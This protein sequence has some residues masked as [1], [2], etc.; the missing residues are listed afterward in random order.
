MAAKKYE[1]YLLKKF[2]SVPPPFAADT[3]AGLQWGISGART[4]PGATIHFGGE[5]FVK[6]ILL[7]EAPHTHDAD[8]YLIFMGGQL[9]DLF[10]NFDAEIDFW[11]GEEQEKYL[12]TEPTIIYIP[13]GIPH[14]PLNFRIVNKPVFF[15]IILQAPK[16][17][18]KMNGKLYSFDD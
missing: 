4:F 11:M 1:K 14:T 5:V 15:N 18:K 3:I 8:E 10:S 6:P 13:K 17:S 2:S 16:F 9:P 12:I 7:E